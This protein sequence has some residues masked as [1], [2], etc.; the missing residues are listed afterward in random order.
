MKW[1]DHAR[2]LLNELVSPVPSLERAEIKR[3]I[4]EQVEELAGE[5]GHSGVNREEWVVCGY[6]L[7]APVP[8][9]RLTEGYLRKKGYG[10]FLASPDSTL[11]LLQSLDRT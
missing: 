9:K 11:H 7:S 1:S 3:A 2:D 8:V 6:W 10:R 4:K 5:A